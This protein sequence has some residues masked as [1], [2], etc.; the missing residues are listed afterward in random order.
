MRLN[1]AYLSR[2][3]DRLAM[4]GG[5]AEGAQ[6][7]LREAHYGAMDPIAP[8]T[9]FEPRDVNVAAVLFTGIGLLVVLWIVVVA[10]YP[11]FALFA[12]ERAET[13]R[14][15]AA[16]RVNPLPPEPRLQADPHREWQDMLAA[17]NGQLNSYHW[18][19]RTQGTVS[20]PIAEAM[21]IIAARGIPPQPQPPGMTYFDPQEGTR[22]TGFQGK[23]EPR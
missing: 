5:V 2:L 18:I 3:L 12:H 6:S 13:P 9:G 1:R 22:E 7:A 16:A 15:P 4:L 21:K 17:E 23:V 19:N 10:V 8:E 14:M 11:L 20:I